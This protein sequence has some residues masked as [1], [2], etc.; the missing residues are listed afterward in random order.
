M[1]T[2]WWRGKIDA[3]NQVSLVK[4]K[5]H[6]KQ[7]CKRIWVKKAFYSLEL[8]CTEY[9]NI[10]NSLNFVSNSNFEMQTVNSAPI[11]ILNVCDHWHRHN[12]IPSIMKFCCKT[13]WW[14]S[15]DHKTSSPIHHL[16][17]AALSLQTPQ[18]ITNHGTQ[19]PAQ[20]CL[21]FINT[22]LG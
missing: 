5:P 22:E 6:Y 3:I 7:N 14:Q 10:I 18:T 19:N 17:C 4:A 12:L 16:E 1:I 20:Y 13:R 9:S 15:Q 2:A 21:V 8:I 11:V